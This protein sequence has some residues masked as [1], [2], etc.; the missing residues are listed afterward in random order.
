[1]KTR[2]LWM[3]A[4]LLPFLSCNQA[5]KD[6]MPSWNQTPIKES[7]VKFVSEYAKAIPVEDRI[8]VF[9]MDG[10]IACETPLWFEMYAAVYGLNLQSKKDPKLMKYP[11]YRYAWKL[12]ENPADTSVLNHYGPYIDSMVWKAYTGIDNEVYIDTARSYLTRTQAPKYDMKIADMF[13]QPMLEL[14]KYLKDNNFTIYIVSGSTQGCIWSVC[15]QTIGFDR[16][17]Q[18]GTRQTQIPVYDPA[19]KKTMFVLQKGISLPKNDG[20]GKSLNIYSTIGKVPIFAF[21]NT[22]GDFGMFHLTSTSKYPHVE[23][24][25]NH[26]DA[27][28]EYAYPPYHGTPV[29]G[30]QDSLK[31]NNWNQVNMA[32]EFKTVWKEK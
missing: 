16:A 24:L 21:G 5:S 26:D 3:L 10:T 28:R 4:M 14:L 29:P 17:H 8:A 9:D 20:N 6:P 30:W 22:T 32:E 31:A 19:S 12:Q 13:Y 23:Y 27:E 11:E 25:L 15:P 7:I 1:M 2:N 18:I